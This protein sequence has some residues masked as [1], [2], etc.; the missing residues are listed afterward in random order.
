MCA[1]EGFPFL[2]QLCLSE[3]AGD[4]VDQGFDR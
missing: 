3:E 4:G 1:V 2:V